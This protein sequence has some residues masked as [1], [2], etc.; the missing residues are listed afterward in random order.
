MQFWGSVILSNKGSNT[1]DVK[2]YNLPYEIVDTTGY[3]HPTAPVVFWSKAV[4]TD[5]NIIVVAT[6]HFQFRS[7][8]STGDTQ[9]LGT[10]LSNN[11]AFSFC[12]TYH[13]AT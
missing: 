7:S 9:L 1:G 8:A 3:T 5:F 4:V 2:I 13:T 11:T 6:D 12:G 10:D